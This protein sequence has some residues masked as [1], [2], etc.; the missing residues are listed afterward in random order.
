MVVLDPFSRCRAVPP[1]GIVL[2]GATG[3]S[4]TKETSMSSTTQSTPRVPPAVRRDRAVAVLLAPVAAL[5]GWGVLTMAPGTGLRIVG[6]GPLAWPDV[7]VAA[8]VAGLGGWAALAGLE[9]TGLPARRWWTILALLVLVL[10]L[11]APIARSVAPTD[12]AGL[13]ALHLVV[14]GVLIGMLGGR[15]T[16]GSSGS[17]D[18]TRAVGKRTT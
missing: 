15:R 4:M 16:P 8:L 11:P 17:S 3:A 7:L 6:A 18:G 9:R 2:G 5:V 1:A 13:V 14:G 10:S 12:A